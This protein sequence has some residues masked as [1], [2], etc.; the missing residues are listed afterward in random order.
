MAGSLSFFSDQATLQQV[1]T[2]LQDVLMSR[3][4]RIPRFQLVS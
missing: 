3:I 2:E 1:T 4:K